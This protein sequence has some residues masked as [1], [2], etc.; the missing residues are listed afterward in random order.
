MPVTLKCPECGRE[1]QGKARFCRADGARLVE[2]GAEPV[3]TSAAPATPA[4]AASGSASS[5]VPPVVG[6]KAGSGPH[7]DDGRGASAAST[8][9]AGA[10]SDP[11]RSSHRDLRGSIG[12]AGGSRG[13]GTRPGSLRGLPGVSGDDHGLPGALSGDHR[14]ARGTGSG[15]R[16]D[17]RKE[18]KRDH[19]GSLSSNALAPVTDG[20]GEKRAESR[21]AD[22]MIGRVIAGRFEIEKVLGTGATGV[23]Y[24]ATHRA[25]ARKMA[26]KLLRPQF[27]WDD[28]S[29]ERFFR[30]AR[31][32]SMLDHPNIVY[33]YD[34]GRAEQGEPFLVMEYVEGQTL[35][36]AIQHSPTRTLPLDRV[37]IVMSQVAR[38]LAHAHSRGVIHRDIKPENIMLVPQGEYEDL[39]KLL[40]FGVAKVANA[41]RVTGV[42]QVTGTAEFI[43]PET[44]MDGV[45]ITSAV[46]LYA[47]GIIFH[48][49]LIGRP[50]F[51]GTL[52]VVL[53]QHVEMV[54]P[55]LSER[56]AD[57]NLPIELDDVVAR[58]LEK[59]PGR[60]PSAVELSEVLDR[61]LEEWLGREYA[62]DDASSISG[63]GVA[64]A[65]TASEGLSGDS[66]SGLSGLSS[67]GS[68]GLAVSADS[69]GSISSAST[70]SGLSSDASAG[71]GS[72]P[73]SADKSGETTD[74]SLRAVPVVEFSDL[75]T[76]PLALLQRPTLM[77]H[78]AE[79]KTEVIDRLARPTQVVA[80]QDWPTRMMPGLGAAGA[81]A[82][83]TQVLP[84]LRPPRGPTQEQMEL[85]ELH[86]ANL[87]KA[88]TELAGRLW[89]GGWP[90]ALLN[91]Q[92]HI[93][94][95]DAQERKLGTEIEAHEKRAREA[96]ELLEQHHEL[97]LKVLG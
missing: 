5:A 9:K 77:V 15:A 7:S 53:H 21:R 28:R 30:E 45:E 20:F 36:E 50:P 73:A 35:H 57:P 56:S 38:A 47:V 42:G 32:Y 76:Q 46:D 27:V 70:A 1:F 61:L 26:V 85:V 51:T 18:S 97:R 63:I 78:R 79:R 11:R 3:V 71:F 54:P 74:T 96:P 24:R 64:S 88:A 81:P 37:L 87:Y 16:K 52:D 75:D 13:T 59:D 68:L 92:Q 29:M 72:T 43:A 62:V 19:S 41:E 60:R 86:S 65:I 90:Q 10:G 55:L 80:R 39:A 95:C 89:P 66:F 84:Q 25:L 23:V 40:D 17:P 67:R 4:S 58:L 6:D 82:R 91:L 69:L 33:L 49:A 8:R 22:P 48:D 83:P 94:G 93:E 34:F 14:K 12:A 44:L 31:T 2:A